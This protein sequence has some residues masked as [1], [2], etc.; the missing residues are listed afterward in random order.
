M[1]EIKEK[2]PS[3]KGS[4]GYLLNRINKS[5]K[6]TENLK[7]VWDKIEP[8]VKRS[9]KYEFS[10][11]NPNYWAGISEE[12]KKWKARKGYPATIGIMTGALKIAA[13]DK[14]KIKKRR[15]EFIYTVNPSVKGYKGKS[16]G[17][18]AK[19]FDDERPI[20]GHTEKFIDKIYKEA[21]RIALD[22]ASR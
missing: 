14:A 11:A 19:Y 22:W 1:F 9:V 20:F 18:Y 12:Y 3:G 13:S 7:D 2:K 6:T 8:D 5:V 10:R 16:V 21:V 15:K 4:I 17:A